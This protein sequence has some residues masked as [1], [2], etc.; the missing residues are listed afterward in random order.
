MQDER[1]AAFAAAG[2]PMRPGGRR[3]HFGC[4]ADTVRPSL[5]RNA[6]GRRIVTIAVC[7]SFS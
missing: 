3:L 5:D 4:A 2:S 6:P 7:G 1:L